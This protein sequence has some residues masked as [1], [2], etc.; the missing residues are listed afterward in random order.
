[1]TIEFGLLLLESVLLVA[2][3]MLLVYGI[4]EGKRRDALLKEV[5]RATKVL[6]RQE[7]FLS[8]MEAMLDA[9]QEIIGCIT[10]T[11]PSGGGRSPRRR[12]GYPTWRDPDGK[13]APSA[14]G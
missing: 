2:T 12:N 9:K 6:T 11:P 8:I 10:G 3:I 4:H 13:A 14:R 7:Y 5:G 1:M